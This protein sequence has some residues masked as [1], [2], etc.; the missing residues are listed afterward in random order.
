MSLADYKLAAAEMVPTSFA[1]SSRMSA[2]V[3]RR[4]EAGELESQH[5]RDARAPADRGKQPYRREGEG[6]LRFTEE[7]RRDVPGDTRS[8]AQRVLRGGRIGLARRPV[9]D[10]RAVADGPD[11]RQ[12]G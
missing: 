6:C 7:L 9:G 5:V 12:V 10:A 1:G 2:N 11:V 3:S 8:L 4:D